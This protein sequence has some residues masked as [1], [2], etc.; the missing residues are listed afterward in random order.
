[1]NENLNTAA[2]EGNLNAVKKLVANG[3]NINAADNDG[4]TQLYCAARNGHLNVVKYLVSQGANINARDIY[5][6]LWLFLYIFLSLL[7]LLFSSQYNSHHYGQVQRL[8]R[9][10]TICNTV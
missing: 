7:K 2:R 9:S 3:A 4:W 5:S 1:M 10:K 6:M 8:K